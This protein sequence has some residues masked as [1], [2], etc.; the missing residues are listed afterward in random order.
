MP[1]PRKPST[2]KRRSVEDDAMAAIDSVVTK[3]GWLG[4]TVI[5]NLLFSGLRVVEGRRRGDKL[6]VVRV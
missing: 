1:K 2:I 3:H 6:K 5:G 4:L